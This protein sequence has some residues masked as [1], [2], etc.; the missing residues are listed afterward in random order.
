MREADLQVPILFL[1]EMETEDSEKA[2]AALNPSAKS[3][4]KPH[5]CK[6]R[7]ASANAAQSREERRHY[8]P[9]QIQRHGSE[10]SEKDI[11]L[12]CLQSAS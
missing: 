1:K 9:H 6:C 11:L 2:E 12:Q 4:C 5:D 7:T 10:V 8:P 3:I